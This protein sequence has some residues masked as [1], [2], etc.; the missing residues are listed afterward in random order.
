MFS[1]EALKAFSDFTKIA[2][3]SNPKG[4]LDAALGRDQDVFQQR[5]GTPLGKVT[6]Y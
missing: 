5:I 1:S 6:T 2:F 4:A 3:P